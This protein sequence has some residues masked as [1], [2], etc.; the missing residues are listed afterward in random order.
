MQHPPKGKA[1]PRVTK[2]LSL[3]KCLPY[4]E[5]LRLWMFQRGRVHLRVGL[6]SFRGGH[7]AGGGGPQ[8]RARH[9]RQLHR[10]VTPYD[11]NRPQ[12]TPAPAT[13]P[14]LRRR[15]SAPPLASLTS[16]PSSGQHRGEEEEDED[17]NSVGSVDEPSEYP[18][19]TSGLSSSF[20][21]D[22]ITIED[23]WEEDEEEGKEADVKGEKISDATTGE[24]HTPSRLVLPEPK[25]DASP[26]RLSDLMNLPPPSH[27]TPAAPARSP[28][29]AESPGLCEGGDEDASAARILKRTSDDASN[30]GSRGPTPGSNAGGTRSSTQQWRMR[31]VRIRAQGEMRAKVRTR[32]TIRQCHLSGL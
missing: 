12:P 9:P 16:T 28:A 11:P 4:R 31:S 30:P 13:A 15:S 29:A 22:E 18:T 26:T 25:R 6:Q 24:V 20:N 2:F 7:D 10:T 5:F 3:D 14:T 1:A 32:H 27:S 21:P 19:D 17:G 23:E 8:R